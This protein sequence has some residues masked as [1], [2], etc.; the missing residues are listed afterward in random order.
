MQTTNKPNRIMIFGRSGSGKSTFAL[1]LHQELGIPVH[2]L[3]RYYFI[4]N[5]IKR[6]Y[7]E[8]MQDQQKLVDQEQWIIDGTQVSSLETRYRRADVCVY[9]DYPFWLCLWRIVK[10]CFW[11]DP[12]ILDRAEGCKE[13]IYWYFIK[14]TWNFRKRIKDVLP[15]L[16][17]KYGSVANI[18]FCRKYSSE[19]LYSS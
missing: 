6:D 18:R 8:F 1:Q 4:H 5:W 2:H 15:T 16:R 19:W 12:R 17:Q 10:R 7:Q 3:D 9:F 14:Y 11:K 13:K